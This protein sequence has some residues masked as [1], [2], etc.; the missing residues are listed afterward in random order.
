M[1]LLNEVLPAATSCASAAGAASD[2]AMA[3]SAL[4]VSLF[5]MCSSWFRRGGWWPFVAQGARKGQA[6]R[7]TSG[8]HRFSHFPESWRSRPA[9]PLVATQSISDVLDSASQSASAAPEASGRTAHDH[10]DARIG[11]GGSGP[12]R[13]NRGGGTRDR[14]GRGRD[15]QCGGNGAL[16][17]RWP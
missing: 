11:S 16:R 13:D 8:L 17:N 9:Q 6:R 10:H 3:T 5:I 14:A 2:D 12:P 4:S 1:H 15:R 7:N